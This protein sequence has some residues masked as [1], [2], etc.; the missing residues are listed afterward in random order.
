MDAALGVVLLRSFPTTVVVLVATLSV[1]MGNV[2]DKGTQGNSSG[3]RAFIPLLLVPFALAEVVVFWS[4][5]VS[6][7]GHTHGESTST[8]GNT[9]SWSAMLLPAMLMPTMSMPTRKELE[10]RFPDG[11]SL[12]LWEHPKLSHAWRALRM[13]SDNETDTGVANDGGEWY[14]PLATD[15]AIMFPR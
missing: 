14:V 3:F 7:Y 15:L 10:E 8:R 12:L 9:N 2:M 13:L 11:M 5:F 6:V 4:K 1:L